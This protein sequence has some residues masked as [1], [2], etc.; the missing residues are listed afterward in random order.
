[1]RRLFGIGVIT[2]LLVAMASIGFAAA[3]LNSSKS[4]IY[5]LVYDP[6]LVTASQAAALV[7]EFDRVRPMDEAAVRQVLQK[8]F[9]PANFRRII[10]QPPAGAGKQTTV[11]LLK[12]PADE[13]EAF[14]FL[15]IE[16]DMKY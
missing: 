4:N 11:I 3:S 7:A 5:R 16:M 13:A 14:K 6:T 9:L 15:K 10:V 8:L 2:G 1:M 12:N